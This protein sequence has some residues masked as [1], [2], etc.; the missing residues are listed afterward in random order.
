MDRSKTEIDYIHAV[1]D[2]EYD[3]KT[4]EKRWALPDGKYEGTHHGYGVSF[5]IGDREFTMRVTVG[6]RGWSEVWVIA[7]K[8]KIEIIA[9]NQPE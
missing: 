4:G 3:R 1:V 2:L 9:R 8:G 6:V 5:K 7:D